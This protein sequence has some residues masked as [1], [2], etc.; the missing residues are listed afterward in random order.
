MRRSRHEPDGL[1]AFLRFLG[2]AAVGAFLG[3]WISMASEQAGRHLGAVVLAAC[4][5]CGLLALLHPVP[6]R[7]LLERAAPWVLGAV[8]VAALYLVLLAAVQLR[9]ARARCLD[10]CTAAGFPAMI[11]APEHRLGPRYCVCSD[12]ID[13][14]HPRSDDGICLGAGRG[15]GGGHWW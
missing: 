3:F 9:N 4:L 14:E 12:R 8:A 5:L 11:Y 15:R 10:C 7:N 13:P 6:A 1:A 2:G